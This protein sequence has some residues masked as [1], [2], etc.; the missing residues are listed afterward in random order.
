MPD[1]GKVF[2]RFSRPSDV[3]AFGLGFTVA[4]AADAFAWAGGIPT[5]DPLTAGFCGGVAAVGIKQGAE[6]TLSSAFTR[7]QIRRRIKR[8]IELSSGDRE[9]QEKMKRAQELSGTMDV[10][11]LTKVVQESEAALIQGSPPRILTS[12]RAPTDYE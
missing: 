9:L 7:R 5:V 11:A 4:A 12:E 2:E 6:A 8:L 3:F 10:Q 1:F